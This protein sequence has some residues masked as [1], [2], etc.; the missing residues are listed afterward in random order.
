MAARDAAILEVLQQVRTRTRAHVSVSVSDATALGIALSCSITDH[1]SLI[2]FSYDKGVRFEVADA[3]DKLALTD[4]EFAVLFGVADAPRSSRA[5]GQ[6]RAFEQL[7]E[8]QEMKTMLANALTTTLLESGPQTV[9]KVSP[10]LRVAAVVA[11]CRRHDVE[12][13][14]SAVLGGIVSADSRRLEDLRSGVEDEGIDVLML[15]Q[16]ITALAATVAS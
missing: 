12:A 15:N 10:S 4:A 7:P 13:C 2:E 3:A 16:A 1:Q 9:W 5:D 8:A 11:L 6:L 14:L